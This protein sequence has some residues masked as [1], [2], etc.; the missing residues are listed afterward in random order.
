MNDQTRPDQI[1]P[2]KTIAKLK[3][4]DV[5]Y[6]EN[7]SETTT[8]SRLNEWICL[9]IY[10]LANIDVWSITYSVQCMCVKSID[11]TAIG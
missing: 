2:E 5:I 11:T 7:V 3:A 6:R 4:I 10:R 9:F 8:K 1:M